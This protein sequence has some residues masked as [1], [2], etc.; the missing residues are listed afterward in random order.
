MSCVIELLDVE[1]VLLELYYSS[2]VIIYV[3]VVRRT[4]YG[5]NS[6]ELLRAVPFMHFITIELGFMR[7]QNR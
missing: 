6:G 7:T 3:A 5:D 4:K 2:F 1:G